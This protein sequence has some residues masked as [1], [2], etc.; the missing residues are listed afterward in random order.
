[1]PDSPINPIY[2]APIATSAAIA[3]TLVLWILNLRKK[4]LSY[5]ILSDTPIISCKAD[6]Q[7]DFEIRFRGELVNDVC[8]VLVKVMNSGNVPIRSADYEGRL[9]IAL[10]KGSKL[11]MADIEETFPS[12]LEERGGGNGPGSL[13]ESINASDIIFRPVLL[14]GRDHF[15]AKL[16][17]SESSGPVSVSAHVEGL[18][19]VKQARENR[20][21]P[22]FLANLGA[23]IMAISLFFLD[24]RALF[25]NDMLSYLPYLVFFLLGYVMLLSGAYFPRLNRNSIKKA[26]GRL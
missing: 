21:L 10:S 6:I 14:N 8:L 9:K 5:E 11:I 22:I 15:T 26:F 17:I 23:F 16:L 12:N 19:E 18:H 25:T 3:V 24:P 1:M 20:T 4:E 7:Q 13:I 2:L